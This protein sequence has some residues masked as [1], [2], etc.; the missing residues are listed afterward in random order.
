MRHHVTHYLLACGFGQSHEPALER[1]PCA[2]LA[3]RASHLKHGNAIAVG[4]Q[5]KRWPDG[6][7]AKH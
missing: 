2:L 7:K 5:P 1:E 4:C 3:T 6:S